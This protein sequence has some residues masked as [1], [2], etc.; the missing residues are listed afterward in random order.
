MFNEIQVKDLLEDSSTDWFY[1]GDIDNDL[2]G[3][4]VSLMEERPIYRD[5]PRSS[6]RKIISAVVECLQ[7]I[8]N[9]APKVDI[10]HAK[11]V[12][13][14]K[15]FENNKLGFLCGNIMH[16]REVPALQKKLELINAASPKQLREMYMTQMHATLEDANRN[17]AGLGLFEIARAVNSPI[18]FEFVSLPDN[19]TFFSVELNLALN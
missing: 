15:R 10:S 18:K 1:L 9:Y 6:R 17:S 5:I 16:T 12:V 2:I 14:V 8:R 3:A 19:F 11:S 7:N 13:M 4:F